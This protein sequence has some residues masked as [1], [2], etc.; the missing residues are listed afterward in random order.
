MKRVICTMIII[1]SVFLASCSGES[2]EMSTKSFTY[3]EKITTTQTE[4]ATPATYSTTA[5]A[6]TTTTMGTTATAEIE[7]PTVNIKEYIKSGYQRYSTLFTA[8]DVETPTKIVFNSFGH[9][10]DNATLCYDK[11]SGE[12]HIFCNDPSCEHGFFSDMTAWTFGISCPAAM[13]GEMTSTIGALTIAPMYL[14]GRIY[15]VCFS[16]IYSCTENADDLREEFKFGDNN[17]FFD[18]WN[19]LVKNQFAIVTVFDDG[20]NIFFR[21]VDE[22]NNIIQYRYDTSTRELHDMT[23]EIKK[24][25]TAL[26]NTVYVDSAA[27]GKI[28][29]AVYSGVTEPLM[30]NSSNIYSSGELVGYYVTD[31]DFSSFNKVEKYMS[32]PDFVTENGVICLSGNHYVLRDYFGEDIVLIEDVNKSIGEDFS[33]IYINSK[34]LYYVKNENLKIGTARNYNNEEY[35]VIN[36]SGGKIYRYDF[37]TGENVCVFDNYLCD[38]FRAIFFDETSGVGFIET[39]EFAEIEKGKMSRATDIVFVKLEKSN[40]IFIVDEE[41]TTR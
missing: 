17:V 30:L 26:G 24:A 28:Y 14:N 19:K 3:E 2:L 11:T 40:G 33:A 35:D 8:K 13:I 9:V 5:T 1:T 16:G 4:T 20:E 18:E 34:Y 31:Y 38:N 22:E 21:H 7:Q 36:K 27:D 15:F 32:R 29:L 41:I 39:E 23:E 12:M 10:G 37:E 25:E 6:T